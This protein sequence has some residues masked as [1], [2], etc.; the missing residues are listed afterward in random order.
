ME[1]PAAV[2]AAWGA[3]S[4]CYSAY[5]VVS[6]AIEVST[7]A[8][9][10]DVQ[11]RVER[12]RFDVWGRTLGFLDEKT[13]SPRSLDRT[14]FSI[15]NGGLSHII[16]VETANKLICDLLAAI[17]SALNEF[18][19][20]AEKYS[21][22]TKGHELPAVSNRR[23]EK[24]AAGL[25]K[26][27]SSTKVFTKHVVY[28]LVDKGL[29]DQLIQTLSGLN[30]SLEK[31]LTL[32]QKVQYAKAVSS[33]VLVKYQQP[34][35]VGALIEALV[36]G[37][38]TNARPGILLT[39]ARVKQLSVRLG[40]PGHLLDVG[41]EE[42]T[43]PGRFSLDPRLLQG[44]SRDIEI[45]ED[46]EWPVNVATYT[47]RAQG[48]R[49][50]IVEWRSAQA[51]TDRGVIEQSDLARR[52]DAIVQ[53]LHKTST[54][55]D[56]EDYR[57]LDCLGYI[58]GWATD[59]T[60]TITDT[61]GLISLVP[62]WAEGG[63]EPVRL[64]SL[65]ETPIRNDPFP[66]LGFW[67][68]LLTPYESKDPFPKPSLR[69]RFRLAQQLA[70]ALYQLQCSNWLH[71]NLSSQQVVF[72]RDKITG[73]LRLD[74]PYL[75]GFQYSRS[76]DNNVGGRSTQLSE[77][78]DTRLNRESQKPYLPQD[79]TAAGPRRYRRSDD[80][81][82]MGVMLF[83]IA[84]WER[85]HRVISG[86]G[87]GFQDTEHNLIE[88]AARRLPAEVGELYTDAVLRCLRGLRP[89]EDA[90]AAPL[91]TNREYDGTYRGEDPEYGLEVDF[92]WKVLREIEKCRV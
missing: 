61:I 80:V 91:L 21:L 65:L 45:R 9:R 8:K 47:T 88:T 7:Q 71:R 33:G 58:K 76:D 49:Q 79:F 10:W 59:P 78:M 28:V 31:L 72:F 55:A 64:H 83:E 75:I 54:M 11:M 3:F 32:S 15:N 57:L 41:A 4:A 17:S 20:T 23:L 86:F 50:V 70:N 63:A 85:A 44:L 24:A 1:V 13:G 5:Q 26:A 52:R 37:E 81:Y 56:A 90:A 25:S 74:Q 87:S 39:S 14:D 53:L 67:H 19:E 34:N 22:G 16:E 6:E 18:R 92:L 29:V 27:W 38:Q 30:D 84:T 89:G 73:E 60:W 77:G 51:G 36:D 48:P 82:S 43:K 68:T 46:S 35:E 66:G 42:E 62:D 69:T 12:V 40:M 2:Q